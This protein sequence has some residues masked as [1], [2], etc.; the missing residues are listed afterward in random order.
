MKA[1]RKTGLVREAM[2]PRNTNQVR[3]E[4]RKKRDQN[5]LAL[6]HLNEIIDPSQ[7]AYVPG[8]SVMDNI[9]SNFYIKNLCKSKKNRWSVNF[10][11]C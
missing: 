4:Q 9:R 5:K 11:R 2:A 10:F 8:Q 3:S 7:T 1:L 6:D